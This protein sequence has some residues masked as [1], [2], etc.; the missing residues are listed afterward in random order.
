MKL[1]A[2]EANLLELLNN[3]SK[4]VEE[5]LLSGLS[6]ASD[7]TRQTLL[8]AF[9]EASRMRLLRLG[10]TLRVASEELGRFTR[11]DENFSSKRFCFFLNRAWMLTRGMI[12]AITFG[13]EEQWRK[14]AWNPEGRPVESLQVVTIGVSKR[15]VPGTFCAF[16]FRLRLVKDEAGMAAGTP[17]IWSC[18]FPMKPGTEIQPEV[19]LILTQKQG[20]KANAFL[21]GKVIQMNKIMLTGENGKRI[22]LTQNSTVES[23]DDFSNWSAFWNWDPVIALDLLKSH[24]PGPFDLDIELQVEAFWSKW[25]LGE[26]QEDDQKEMLYYPLTGDGLQLEV[27]VSANDDVLNNEIKTL[28]KRLSQPPLYGIMHFE[29]CKLIFQPLSVLENNRPQFLCLSQKK[30]GAAELLRSLK[31]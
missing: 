4:A 9:Q 15:F 30:T 25:R 21:E 1:P 2:K 27:Q 12:H 18:I 7:S 5:I 6:T 22:S 10:S 13:S 17:L 24:K 14:L 3:L 16:E 29:M 11:N 26:P 8:I 31:F 28:A 20:F 23:Q 19:F